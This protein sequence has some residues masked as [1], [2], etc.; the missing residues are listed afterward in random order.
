MSYYLGLDLG[1]SWLKATIIDDNGKIVASSNK[2]GFISSVEHGFAEENPFDWWRNFMEILE[3]LREKCD[4]T[5]IKSIALSGQMH[6]TVCYDKT[7]NLL[8]PAIIWPDARSSKQVEQIEKE[9]G[10]EKIYKITGNPVFTGLML[11]NLLWIK[12]NEPRIYK[13]IYK[14]SSPKDYLALQLTGKLFC[15]PSDALATACY[16]YQ[17]QDWSTEMIKKSGLN[18]SFFPEIIPTSKPYG[19]ITKTV[20]EVT[21]LPAG[22]PVYG[23]SD[24]A[25]AAMGC[26]CIEEGQSLLAISTGGQFWVVTE[27]KI[28]DKKR[29]LHT[30]NHAIDKYGLTMAATLSAGLSLQWFKSNV[31]GQIDTSFDSFIKDIDTIQIGAN[32]LTFYPYL[33]GERTPFFNASLR[34]AFIGQSLEHNR[35]H[36][37]RAVMEGVAFSFKNCLETLTDSGIEVRKIRLSGGGSKNAIWRQIITD[38]LNIPTEIINIEDH[39]PYGA[40]VFAKFALEGTKNLSAFYKNALVV[41]N[42]QTPIKKN[43]EKY[44]AVY[45]I[46]K[47]HASYLN[48]FYQS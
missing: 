13:Q 14:I 10:K 33:A 6:G 11:P 47:Q 41:Q 4:L 35:L 19:G 43:V 39:S 22:I 34:G 15:E 16:D 44:K 21:G 8:R 48:N 2:E 45:E 7:L 27:K 31:L 37:V 17:K 36:F 30:L 18:Q 1:T 24:Q 46:Y 42:K 28:Y 32:G 3:N 38:V 29:R 9:F 23:G 5:K 12:E 40:A 20:A 26:G 25:M